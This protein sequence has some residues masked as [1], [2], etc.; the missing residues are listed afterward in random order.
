MLRIETLSLRSRFGRRVLLLF[1]VCAVVPVL[2]AWSFSFA[3]VQQASR[4]R[5]IDQLREFS[6]NY[7][8]A[9]LQ[10]L[11]AAEV[12]LE[13]MAAA[14][15]NSLQSDREMPSTALLWHALA[16]VDGRGAIAH[17]R[18]TIEPLPPLE[19]AAR[20][21]LDAGEGALVV[22]PPSSGALLPRVFLVV[23]LEHARGLLFGEVNSQFLF[24][25]ANNLPYDI[26]VRL[27]N[28]DGQVLYVGSASADQDIAGARH[29]VSVDWDLFL[30]ARFGAPSL[31]IESTQPRIGFSDADS[32]LAGATPWVL[33]G[34]TVLVCL[35]SSMQIRRN[36][37]PLDELLK[38]TRR[39]AAREF[40]TRVEVHSRDEFQEL[41]DSF[42]RMS[43]S[44]RMQF[45]ALEALS[46]IDRLILSAPG[47]EVILEK[48]LNHVR[49]VT[50]CK[51]VSVTLIDPDEQGHGRV[52]LNDGDNEGQRDIKR[53]AI[54]RDFPE[55][56][57]EGTAPL[58]DLR[59]DKDI[60]PYAVH[61][62]DAGALWG[63]VQ[64]VRGTQGLNA[65]LTLGYR[66]APDQENAK[67]GFAHDFADR[68]AV[69]INSVER[70]E[71]LYRQAHYDDLTG[72]PNRQLF[73]DRLLHEIARASR[74][75][76][77]LALLY[78]DL[79]NFKR[80]NDTLGHGA[81]D[82]LIQVAARRLDTCT[83]RSDTVAR[84]GG[85]E[86]VVILGG[87]QDPDEAG[88]AADRLLAELA[89]P[90]SIRDREFQTRASVGIAL[91][92]SDGTT[93]E[94]L[95]KNADTAMYRAKDDG[96][97]R[98][99]FFEA[100]MN[101]RAQERWSLETGLHRAL[102]LRQF[103]LHYQPQFELTSGVVNGAEALIRWMHPVQGQRP[104]TQFIPAAEESGLIADIGEW[105]L[106]EACE[107]FQ[108]WQRAGTN[109]P[110]IAINVSPGQ[111]RHKQ[112]ADQVR[113]ALIRFSVPPWS[114]ELEITESVLLAG[115]EQTAQTLRA[116]TELGVGIALDDFGT[117]YSSLSYLRRCPVDVI[118]IDRSFVSDIPDNPDACAIATA[119]VAMARSLRKATTAEGIET[120]AQLEYL[121]TLGCDSGQGYLYSKALPAD[122]LEQLLRNPPEVVK[123]KIV[124]EP[125]RETRQR[126]ASR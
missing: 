125:P 29:L 81:G 62:A 44:L 55:L 31:K 98:A 89:L 14:A 25:D 79:D 4:Q 61:V 73:K 117:G 94:E 51:C 83:K 19:Q 50:G 102:Q 20:R 82:E 59:G 21:R 109:V 123:P 93:P 22:V 119:I 15:A 33:L 39:I 66:E 58:L 43:D 121:R 35:L 72:L 6:S 113:D 23:P 124:V 26:T 45:A 126:R 63:L 7:G 41:G 71:R 112:F 1:L 24:G 27:R 95:L 84:L 101:E 64:P 52:Y 103:V 2:I 47:I 3:H 90:V 11:D 108:R 42:N 56:A 16:I 18:G 80:V 28:V 100:H 114:L 32:A 110:R 53:M 88:K 54:P 34:A 60:P 116:L 99:T 120:V 96:R 10:K 68:L 49:K 78:I 37:A 9:L 87:L 5:Q 86:F 30:G 105:V 57:E 118:K 115:D 69:A 8:L 65:I 40:A 91:Y 12:A 13:V 85:D 17:Q 70:E 36:L 38:G 92:P 77:Q 106:N 104:P 74:T 75:E 67:G 111:L 97:G 46:E 122:E 107:Q 48:L 76:E